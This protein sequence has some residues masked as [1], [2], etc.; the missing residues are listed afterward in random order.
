MTPL[1][2]TPRFPSQMFVFFPTVWGTIYKTTKRTHG[3]PWPID[4]V[5]FYEPS[6]LEGFTRCV[7]VRNTPPHTCCS[8]DTSIA[9]P[10]PKRQP[11][12]AAT[13]PSARRVRAL[14]NGANRCRSSTEQAIRA[15]QGE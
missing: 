11:P 10:P 14:Q 13:H 12:A 1:N 2:L 5:K 7:Q 9:E 3:L 8:I 6:I 15:E 4:P